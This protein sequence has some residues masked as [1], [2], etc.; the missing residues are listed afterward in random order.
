M[1]IISTILLLTVLSCAST[2]DKTK[3]KETATVPNN[4]GNT[5]IPDFDIDKSNLTG[6][7]VRLDVGY[8][9][10]E[11]TCPQWFETKQMNDTTYGRRYFYLEQGEEG[12]ANADRLFD[13]NNLPVHIV[14]TGQ[15]YS[16]EG[17]PKNY[18]PTKGHP[19]PARV[20]R[21]KKIEIVQLGHQRSKK[22]A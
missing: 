11:C 9:A 10:I 19:K 15:F 4:I 22:K 14:V 1:K 16:K 2:K 6:K 3:E 17:Y 12:I 20:F 8:A 7:N 5:D 21:Y 13:G 18:H